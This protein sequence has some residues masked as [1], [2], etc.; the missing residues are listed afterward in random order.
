MNIYTN[1][2]WEEEV[3]LFIS[4]ENIVYVII[5]FRHWWIVRI[6]Q[7]VGSTSKPHCNV[8]EYID[9]NYFC[10][11]R[12]FPQEYSTKI[13]DYRIMKFLLSFLFEFIHSSKTFCKH[14]KVFSYLN[15]KYKF[16][17]YQSNTPG[18]DLF[19]TSKKSLAAKVRQQQTFT[20][21]RLCQHH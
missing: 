8:N 20:F 1:W 2:P 5:V 13:R 17:N 11:A 7:K 18:Q 12:L 16:Q 21:S 10:G 14:Q 3:Y 9:V 15:R 4:W 6:K 19:Q